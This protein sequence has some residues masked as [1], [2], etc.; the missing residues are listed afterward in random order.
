LSIWAPRWTCRCSAPSWAQPRWVVSSLPAWESNRA[1]LEALKT[2][3]FAGQ[4]AM[5]ARDVDHQQ[6]LQNAGVTQVLNPF[7]DA[8]DAAARSLRSDILTPEKTP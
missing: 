1:L 6:Q 2:L 7:D 4:V 3:G 8:A 5:V